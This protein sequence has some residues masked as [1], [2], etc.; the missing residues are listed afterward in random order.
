MTLLGLR[1]RI[2][3]RDSFQPVVTPDV[4]AETIAAGSTGDAIATVPLAAAPGASFPLYSRQL[5]VTNGPVF[6]GGML[7]F[8]TVP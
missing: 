6:P 3:A 5:A 1:Q 2:I 4:M 8:I 7:T